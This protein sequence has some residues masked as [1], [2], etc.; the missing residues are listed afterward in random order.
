[1]RMMHMCAALTGALGLALL[2]V[3]H[4]W[5]SSEPDFGPVLMAA[6]AQMSAAAAGL[7]IA[8]GRLNAIAGGLILF[9][10]NLFAG[11]IYLSALNPAHPFHALT[12][13][14]G[15]AMILGWLVLAFARP[16]QS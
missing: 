1:M 7:A 4:H 14:G 9:G 2:A 6:I 15:A 12:P 5:S 13:V 11:V 8:N 3:T 16:A 10:A